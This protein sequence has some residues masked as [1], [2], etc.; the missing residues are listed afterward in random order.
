MKKAIVILLL[1][2]GAAGS[3]FAGGNRQSSRGSDE[4]VRL[5][6]WSKDR[7]YMTVLEPLRVAYN[8]NNKDNIYLEEI[9]YFGDDFIQAIELT[10]QTGG[11]GLP[12]LFGRDAQGAFQRT[13]NR[14][15]WFLD[16]D[17]WLET[18][19]APADQEFKRIFSPFK[20]E[21]Y[22]VLDGEWFQTGVNAD[23]G[24]RL[25]WNRDIFRKAGLPDRP[26]ETLDEMIQFAR[27]I[28]ANL[29]GEGIY[30]FAMNMKGPAS[31][32]GRSLS[33]QWLLATGIAG[34]G[35]Q[36][37][38]GR[39][40]YDSEEGWVLLQAWQQL[41]SPDIVFPG[42]ESLD[43][44]PLR[45]QFADGKIGMYIS[46]GFEPLV[47]MPEAQFP[48]TVDYSLAKIP[49]P[50]GNYKAKHSVAIS[51]LNS[52]N[53]R[54]GHLEEAWIAYRDFF[55]GIDTLAAMTTAGL[56]TSPVP[57]VLAKA[58]RPEFYS[59]APY[60][61][62]QPDIDQ[63]AGTI[64]Y[65]GGYTIEGTNEFGV[66]DEII[67]NRLGRD[68]AMTLL[69]DLAERKQRGMQLAID[70]GEYSIRLLEN[71]DPMDLSKYTLGAEIP[72]SR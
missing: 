42:A 16:F 67:Q 59:K 24:N 66:W 46:Y 27:Q 54:G 25:I 72:K 13:I 19:T 2:L 48:T 14:Q 4:K 62:F 56:I 21:G 33:P 30:G 57:E 50:G 60:A 32:Y 65:N 15:G 10:V 11:E 7:G 23:P 41:L 36:P 58:A 3:V 69:R 47:Y 64:Y 18:H 44:D 26:P 31:A 17:K 51:G 52:I 61:N 45:A 40:R 1:M 22:T 38:L 28:T 49:V 9:R 71:Y 5:T 29:R 35:Y 6:V 68:Q 43:I 39:F 63:W 37:N 12:D 20:A 70:R 53:A 34:T 55:S 8:E